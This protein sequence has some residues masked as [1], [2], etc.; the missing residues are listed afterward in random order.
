MQNN[1]H[2]KVARHE[3]LT[4]LYQAGVE[5]AHDCSLCHT[6]PT[7]ITGFAGISRM[8]LALVWSDT[9][10]VFALWLAHSCEKRISCIIFRSA[11]HQPYSIY[12]MY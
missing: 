1:H 3:H 7:L 12:I 4:F 11:E 6:L 8:T 9:F 10:T 2:G 5:G